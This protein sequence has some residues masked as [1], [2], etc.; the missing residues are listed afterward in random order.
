[1]QGT[2]WYTYCTQPAA[3][4]CRTG[5]RIPFTDH[6]YSD[7]LG[8]SQ[9]NSISEDSSCF[10]LWQN[11]KLNNS[12]FPLTNSLVRINACLGKTYTLLVKFSG[13]LRAAWGFIF[14][15]TGRAS[16]NLGIKSNR[17][18]VSGHL[19]G[20]GRAHT[21]FSLRLFLIAP[22]C[23]LDRHHALLIV[24]RAPKPL[25]VACS[26]ETFP[27]FLGQCSQVDLAT[28]LVIYVGG[29]QGRGQRWSWLACVPFNVSGQAR[30]SV[31]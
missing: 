15:W 9:P 10:Y 13:H 25:V 16:W 12:P 11:F 1:M 27:L 5:K 28:F 8:P 3:Q 17:G 29:P 2:M 24:T 23:H 4:T 20:Y 26:L 19:S 6:L 31:E 22:G 21:S 30:N 14:E 18:R 7:S